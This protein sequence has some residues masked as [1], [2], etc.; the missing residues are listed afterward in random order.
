MMTNGV[1]VALRRWRSESCSA[2]SSVSRAL[3]TAEL[4]TPPRKQTE[5]RQ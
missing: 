3:D 2:V 5:V 1:I 4:I